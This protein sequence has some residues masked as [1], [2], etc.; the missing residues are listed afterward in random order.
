MPVSIRVHVLQDTHR[1]SC[2]QSRSSTPMHD[3]REHLCMYAVWSPRCTQASE[4]RAISAAGLVRRP[5]CIGAFPQG[6]SVG[7]SAPRLAECG[8]PAGRAQSACRWPLPAHAR[9]RRPSLPT[10]A[11]WAWPAP[12]APGGS[13]YDQDK[14]DRRMAAPASFPTNSPELLPGS[15]FT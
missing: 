10:A 8:L 15:G 13:S 5:T 1:C 6:G 2:V 12:G 11:G 4:Q 14:T 3:P 9:S 7:S